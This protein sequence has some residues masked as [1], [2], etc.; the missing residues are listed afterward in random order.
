[1]A[2]KIKRTLI[3]GSSNGLTGFVNNNGVAAS[4]GDIKVFG[5][6]H[7]LLLKDAAANAT[8]VPA[9]FGGVEVSYAKQT[10]KNTSFGDPLYWHTTNA[11]VTQTAT[12]H[13]QIGIASQAV[14]TGAGTVKFFFGKNL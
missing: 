6:L 9:T 4:S 7:A 5:S 13:T 2:T 10:N 12:G 8:G 11:E 14:T 3:P 1:M